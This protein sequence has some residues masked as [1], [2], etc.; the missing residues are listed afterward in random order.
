MTINVLVVRG[1]VP[2]V[3]GGR[4][5]SGKAQSVARGKE[6]I[7][8]CVMAGEL[9]HVPWSGVTSLFRDLFSE[10]VILFGG[11]SQ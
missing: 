5:F 2:W 1:R 4:L 9:V 6:L 8:A 10:E 7:I 3:Y 11:M